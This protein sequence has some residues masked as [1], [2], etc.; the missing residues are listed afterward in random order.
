M[1]GFLSLPIL[2]AYV[3]LSF[4]WNPSEGIDLGFYT[5]QYYSLMFVI[6]FWW[7]VHHEKYLQTGRWNH[8]KI[9]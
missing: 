3:F 2:T 1:K 6:A 7:L 9:G 4:T 5:I 8:T